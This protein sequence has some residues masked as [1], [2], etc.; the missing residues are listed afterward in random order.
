MSTYFFEYSLSPLPQD[1]RRPLRKAKIKILD[2]PRSL[3]YA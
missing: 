3:R 1:V 2:I